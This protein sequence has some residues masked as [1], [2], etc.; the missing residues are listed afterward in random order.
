MVT[1]VGYKVWWSR[2]D[3]IAESHVARALIDVHE[4]RQAERNHAWITTLAFQLLHRLLY[5]TV[6]NIVI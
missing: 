4:S 6:K 3:E 1:V 5:Y 2:N